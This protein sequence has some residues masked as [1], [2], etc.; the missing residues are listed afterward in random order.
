MLSGI[1]DRFPN[2]KV[3]LVEANIGWI[4]TVLEQSD[5]MFL[6]FRFWTG[7]HKLK[8]L[9][10]EYFYENMR[11][12][13]MIDTVGVSLRHKC[14][15][16]NIMW[17]T[18]YPHSGTDWPNSR[19]TLERNFAGVPRDEVKKMVRDNAASLYKIDC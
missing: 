11:S 8:K 4:P 12:T 7:G 17:S 2:L 9:P 5:D 19:V 3:V 10:S 14:G 1:F 16:D 18:D 6:R 15:L 13:F